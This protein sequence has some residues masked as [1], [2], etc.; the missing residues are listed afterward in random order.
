MK[1]R[2]RISKIFGPTIQGEGPLI[3]RPIV[4][5]RTGGC[6]YRCSWCDTLY[7]VL[8]EYRGRTHRVA[9][10]GGRTSS[11]IRPNLSFKYTQVSRHAA[12]FLGGNRCWK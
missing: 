9:C 8:P 5:V 2:I 1:E 7:A 11:P 4:F 12:R 6:D 10:P 3:G